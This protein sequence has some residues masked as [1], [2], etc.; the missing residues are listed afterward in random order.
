MNI[1]SLWKEVIEITEKN[2]PDNNLAPILGTGKTINPKFM[3]VFINPTSRNISSDKS[4]KGLR[5]PFIGTKHVW[6]FFNKINII[7]DDLLKE[8]KQNYKNWDEKFS[9]KV[10]DALKQKD[11]F[12][13]NIV[14]NTGKDATLPKSFD[15]NLY[16]PSFKKEIEIINPKYI[17]AFEL[18]PIKALLE[19]DIKLSEYHNYLKK[20]K[21]LKIEKVKI[22]KKEFNLIPVFYPIGRGRPHEA[23]EMLNAALK[24]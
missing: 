19:K 11:I 22:N 12:L 18:I 6:N 15:I 9:K 3:I 21:K 13:T 4:W 14:K 20:N 17:I 1:K 2:Y 24:L 5:Y 16:L 7:E 10:S 8:I 23:I